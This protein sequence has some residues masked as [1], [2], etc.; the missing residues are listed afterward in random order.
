MN[1]LTRSSESALPAI[2]VDG[3]NR[4]MQAFNDGDTQSAPLAINLPSKTGKWTIGRD[5]EVLPAGTRV[6]MDPQSLEVGWVAWYGGKPIVTVM[7]DMLSGQVP[8]KPVADDEGKPLPSEVDPKTGDPLCKV[9]PQYV[10]GVTLE[11]GLRAIIRGGSVG[12]KFAIEDVL[13]KIILR[14][15]TGEAK[16]YP[17]LELAVGSYTNQHGKQSPPKFNVVGWM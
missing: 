8:E 10:V 2:N 7:A 1:A 6:V 11:G 9:S 13:R 3:L 17:V 12:L 16:L 5:Q 4:A 14:A 15:R